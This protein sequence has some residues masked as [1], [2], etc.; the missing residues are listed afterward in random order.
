M[1]W[2][3]FAQAFVKSM[4]QVGLT[5]AY[6]NEES[7]QVV[8]LCFLALPLLPVNHTEL[9]FQD[10]RA[11]VGA[12]THKNTHQSLWQQRLY[13]PA[14]HI[15]FLRAASY[16]VGAH[17]ALVHAWNQLRLGRRRWRNDWFRRRSRRGTDSRWSTSE[18]RLPGVF[19]VAPRDTLLALVPCGHQRFYPVAAWS[20]LNNSNSDARSVSRKTR[21][22]C[23]CLT[24]RLDGSHFYCPSVRLSVCLSVT[25]MNCEYIFLVQ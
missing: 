14:P 20:K 23:G 21:W 2:F 22:C 9:A 8:M 15:Q 3:H 24:I 10:V 16:S 11:T 1:P 19:I 13:I 7:T 25:F 12:D 18:R 6:G 17:S 4:K 5:D